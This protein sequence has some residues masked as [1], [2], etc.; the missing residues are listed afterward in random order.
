MGGGEAM[1]ICFKWDWKSD[2]FYTV[3]VYQIGHFFRCLLEI[4][5]KAIIFQR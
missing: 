1:H 4:S 5:S 3:K 2:T